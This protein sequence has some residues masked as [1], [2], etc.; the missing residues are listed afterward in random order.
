KNNKECTDVKVEVTG[1]NRHIFIDEKE[2]LKLLNA[3]GDLVGKEVK[4]INLQVLEDR[5]ENDK[6]IRNAELFFDN[7]QVLEV[8]VE[9][10]EPVARIFTVEGNSYYIDSST[11]RLPLSDKMSIRVPMFTNFPT[12][13]KKLRSKDSALMVSIK[14]LATFIQADSFWNAQVA[15]IN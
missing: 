13:A 6:W 12:D 5:L 4:D 8:K 14:E 2:V 11:S 7:N 9:E 1:V 3:N 10:R 15:Q